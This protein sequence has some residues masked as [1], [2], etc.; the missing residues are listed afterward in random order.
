M[1]TIMALLH[2]GVGD[3]VPAVQENA[4]QTH[5]QDNIAVERVRTVTNTMNWIVNRAKLCDIICKKKGR[6]CI[7]PSWPCWRLKLRPPHCSQALE[8]GLKIYPHGL[9]EDEETHAT[10]EVDMYPPTKWKQEVLDEVQVKL[11]VRVLD[12]K[13]RQDLT[14]GRDLFA[15]S[16]LTTTESIKIH[17]LLDHS[18]IIHSHSVTLEACVTA[19]LY[20][21]NYQLREEEDLVIM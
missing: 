9:D 17:K 7:K 5:L 16:K 8:L 19:E 15:E 13:T 2:I 20:E 6:A 11:S 1:M 10:F 3:A 4:T 21:T 18:S 14:A 12:S